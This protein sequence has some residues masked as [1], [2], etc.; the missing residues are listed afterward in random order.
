L[1]NSITVTGSSSLSD[2]SN[3]PDEPE[4]EEKKSTKMTFEVSENLN[5]I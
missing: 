5:D 3:M 2:A 4:K 1:E